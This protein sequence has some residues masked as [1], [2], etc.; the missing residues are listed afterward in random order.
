MPSPG[1]LLIILAVI[2]LLFGTRKLRGLGSDL[3]SAIKGFQK[4]MKDDTE[5]KVED[6]SKVA[7]SEKVIEGDAEKVETKK[8]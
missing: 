8:S 1:Q 3:G 6:H 5:K 2:L 4:A 7:Q